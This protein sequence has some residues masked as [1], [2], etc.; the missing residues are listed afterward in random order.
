MKPLWGRAQWVTK[1]RA[2]F[3]PRFRHPW[4]LSLKSEPRQTVGLDH[5]DLILPTAQ[6][7][8]IKVQTDLTCRHISCCLTAGLVNNLLSKLL[9]RIS[10]S[11]FFSLLVSLCQALRAG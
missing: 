6:E 7:P 11:V 3:G 1:L 5:V 4:G 10:L 9:E 8:F 2:C